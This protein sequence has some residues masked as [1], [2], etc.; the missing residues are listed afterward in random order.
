MCGCSAMCVGTYLQRMLVCGCSVMCAGAY[1]WQMLVCGSSLMCVGHM[2]LWGWQKTTFY[3]KR[4]L[5][6][7][8]RFC[9]NVWYIRKIPGT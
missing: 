7:S 5:Y 9:G 1:L 4:T 6:Y 2:C 3:T 8:I